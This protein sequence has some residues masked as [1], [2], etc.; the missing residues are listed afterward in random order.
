VFCLENG[1]LKGEVIARTERAY[2][3][4]NDR[5]GIPGAY[6]IVPVDHTEKS[7]P[8]W[9]QAEVNELLKHVP[10]LD[11]NADYNISTNFGKNA[12]QTQPHLHTHVIPRTPEQG[13]LGLGGL[14][15]LHTS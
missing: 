2:L 1:I 15:R 10:S 13:G 14:I 7:L 9:W 8:D 6:M 12:G 4:A 5:M 11:G 3:I